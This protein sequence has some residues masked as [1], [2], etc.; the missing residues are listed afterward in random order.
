MNRVSRPPTGLEFRQI[1]PARGRARRYHMS[2]CVSLFSEPA[3]LITW[4]R[5]A[6]IPRVRLEVFATASARRRRWNELVDRRAAHGVR[7]ADLLHR[8][9]AES[10]SRRLAHSAL[11]VGHRRTV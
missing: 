5:I 7:A 10:P 2:E 6:H 1:D 9:C 4:G 11:C 8:R 3:I